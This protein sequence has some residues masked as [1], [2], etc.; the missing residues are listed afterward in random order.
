[1]AQYFHLKTRCVVG[2]YVIFRYF[3]FK[4]VIVLNKNTNLNRLDICNYYLAT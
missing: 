3:S 1:M 2:L 4:S